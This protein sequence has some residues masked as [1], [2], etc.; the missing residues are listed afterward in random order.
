MR[1]HVPSLPHTE[2]TKDYSW[3]AYT[4][5]VRKFAGMMTDLGHEVFVYAGEHNEARCTE[6]VQVN[7]DSH[8]AERIPE[9]DVNNPGWQAFAGHTVREIRLRQQPGDYLC[10][11][12]GLAQGPISWNLPE[13]TCVEFGVGY[14]GT[15]SDFRVFES[16]AWMHVVYGAQQGA[17]AANGRFYDRVIP[18]SFEL[19]D[20]PA[21]DGSGGYLLYVGRLTERKGLEILKDMAARIATPI[22]VAGEGDT[23]LLPKR[24]EYVGLVGPAQ[25][26]KLMGGAKALICPTLYLEP[27]GG[28]N[29]EAQLCGTPVITTDWGGFTETVEDGVTGL[30]CHTLGEFCSAAYE[31]ADFDRAYIRERATR[32]YSCGEVKFAYEDYFER[33]E[34]LKGRGWYA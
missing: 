1:F 21:G 5:K 34:G 31:V 4:E 2:T 19:E 27:F 17:H 29:V 11:I 8:F 28:V 14:E 22:I 16:Y 33:L 30:R 15:F 18:N 25:R 23:S 9:F 26:A 3:C 13:L 12:G 24:A 7:Q 6:H 10:I 20:F 32:L